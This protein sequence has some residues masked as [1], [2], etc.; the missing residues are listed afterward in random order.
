MPERRSHAPCQVAQNGVQHV[1]AL[2]EGRGVSR[3]TAPRGRWSLWL[4]AEGDACEEMVGVNV[5]TQ[6]SPPEDR[7]VRCSATIARTDLQLMRTLVVNVKRKR[8]ER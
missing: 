8:T 7:V 2:G 3:P 1:K 6:R 4:E 5:R